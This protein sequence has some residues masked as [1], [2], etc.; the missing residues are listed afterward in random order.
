ML[1][2]LWRFKNS[3]WIVHRDR[4][5]LLRQEC[6]ETK[7]EDTMV[8]KHPPAHHTALRRRRFGF[9]GAKVICGVTLMPIRL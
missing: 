5:H 4:P 6:P 9:S 3:D 7:G 8:W 1:P 2:G